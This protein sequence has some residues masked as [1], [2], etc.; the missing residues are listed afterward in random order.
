LN[1][2]A[3]ALNLLAI[4]LVVRRCRRGCWC[5]AHVVGTKTTNA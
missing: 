1:L 3:I 2:L 4:A 5:G